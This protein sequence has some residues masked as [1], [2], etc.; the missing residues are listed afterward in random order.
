M[1]ESQDRSAD[2]GVGIPD[3]ALPEDLVPA[4]DNPLAEGLEPGDTVDDLLG[5]GKQAEQTDRGSEDSGR[6]D[7]AGGRM[8]DGSQPG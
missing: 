2:A 4:E 3:D 8:T 7:D 1:S 6:A 5:G